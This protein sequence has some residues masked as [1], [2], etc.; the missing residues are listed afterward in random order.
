MIFNESKYNFHWS[1]YSLLD[2]GS[3]SRGKSK[4]RPRNDIKL[5]EGGTVPF[6]QTAEIKASNLYIYSTSQYYNE[7][8]LQQSKLWPKETL[9]ITIAANIADVALLSFPSCFP[10]SVVGFNANEKTTEKY[11]YYLFCYVSN[12]IKKRST[13][14]TQDNINID[15]LTSL[16]FKVPLLDYQNSVVELLSSIDLKIENNNKINFELEAMSKALYD[17]WFLQFEFPN[18]EGK[19]YKSSGGKMVWNEKIK[20]EI[21]EGW[22]VLRVK[23]CIEHINT[24]LNPRDNFILNDGDIK[25]ITVKNLTIDGQLNFNGCD[26][27]SPATKEMINKRSMVSKGD[28]L[29]SSIAP[30]GRCFMVRKTPADW[31][32]NESVFSIRPNNKVSTEY[33]YKYFVSDHFVKKAE[34]SSTGSIFAGIRVSVLENMDIIVPSNNVIKKFTNKVSSIY[35]EKYSLSIQNQELS[36]LRDFLL[37]LLMNGQVTFKEE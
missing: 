28:I 12:E 16:D 9:C 32:I 10:D 7:F 33:L 8:G 6:V 26:T 35:D 4:H 24:G 13:G 31:E 1:T 2:L 25:Y 18:E 20:R 29:F 23:D 3:F 5:F 22:E 36:S 34:N 27:I 14:S 37:P 19:P 21:P 11:M 15:Y 17:Y 30:L